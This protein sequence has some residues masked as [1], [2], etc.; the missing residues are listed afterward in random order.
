MNRLSNVVG[1]TA[2]FRLFVIVSYGPQPE[3]RIIERLPLEGSESRV[4]GVWSARAVTNPP[5]P[6]GVAKCCHRKSNRFCVVSNLWVSPRSGPTEQYCRP[7][8][9]G[10]CELSVGETDRVGGPERP[11]ELF[12]ERCW[13]SRLFRFQDLC[14]FHVVGS[15]FA[16]KTVPYRCKLR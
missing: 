10:V 8:L 5:V 3:N 2:K 1:L 6:R 9:A 15:D 14:G 13:S 16:G 7:A 12:V 11:D 4:L